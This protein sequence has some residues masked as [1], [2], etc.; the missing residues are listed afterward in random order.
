[1]ARAKYKNNP[2]RKQRRRETANARAEK[3]QAEM[4]HWRAWA[5][6]IQD[7]ALSQL[8]TN[9]S[10]AEK[11]RVIR[12]AWDKLSEKPALYQKAIQRE[13]WLEVRKK[14]LGLQGSR[15]PRKVR[16]QIVRDALIKT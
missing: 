10:R 7:E 1:M 6:N 9:A 4:V 11:V 16:R 8:P 2:K 15:V 14:N 5:E 3:R 13:Q 12:V